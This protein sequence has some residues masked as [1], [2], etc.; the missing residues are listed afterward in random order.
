MEGDVQSALPS[1]SEVGVR[2]ATH[3]REIGLPLKLFGGVAVWV[4]CPS[5]RRPPLAR[6]YADVD[7]ATLSAS[8]SDVTRFFESHDYAPDKLFNALHS[9]SRMTFS[10]RAT[11]RPVDV[12]VDQFVQC[13]TIDLR[14]SLKSNELTIPLTDL[15]VTKLQIVQLNDKDL[16]DLCALLADHPV[17]EA[18]PEPIDPRRLIELTSRDWGLEH[19]VR[20][21]LDRVPGA[22]ERFGLAS[23]VAQTVRDRA[24]DV[25]RVLDAAP[26]SIGWRLRAQIGERLRW[27]EIPEETRR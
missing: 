10:D 27:Y 21:T 16:R 7:F 2:L 25:V 13:H 9:A 1:N 23:D 3:A 22:A 17:V 5:A 24:A 19:T 6:E 8:T 14:L 4:R 11:G 26:K 18:T 20:R 12:I 15:L